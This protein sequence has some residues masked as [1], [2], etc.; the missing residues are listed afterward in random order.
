MLKEPIPIT[1]H[2]WDENTI[3]LVSIGCLT[4]NHELYIRDAI[5][6]FLMQKTTFPVKIVVFED[7]S[8]DKTASI[9]KEYEEKYPNL[10]TVFNQPVNTWGKPIRKEAKKVYENERNKAKYIALCEGDD[11]WTDPLKLQKQVSFLEANPDFSLCFT[12]RINIDY[13]GKFI[14]NSELKYMKSEFEHTDM[15]IFCPTLT[16][17]FVAKY[18]KNI[19]QIEVKGGDTVLLVWLSKF[20]KIKYLDDITSCYRVHGDGV[21]SGLTKENK[22]KHLI[23]TR[24]GLLQ[25]I[26]NKELKIKIFRDILKNVINSPELDYKY[27]T[28][29]LNILRYKYHLHDF[30]KVN[31]LKLILYFNLNKYYKVKKYYVKYILK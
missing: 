9:I 25:I 28:K 26:E 23:E 6:G 11:Y 4:Y 29:H 2:V 19:P 18:V 14:E 20:G 27:L 17:L 22:I 1:E 8:T 24:V 21:W 10:F 7:C 16:R 5:E 3:P 12:N 30:L 13:N 31:S 15:P